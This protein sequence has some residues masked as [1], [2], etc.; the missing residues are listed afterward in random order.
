MTMTRAQLIGMTT[1][2]MDANNSA[3]WTPAVIVT[4]LGTVSAREWSGILQANPYYRF[5]QRA[6]TTDA[7]GQFLYTALNSGSADTAQN[8]SRILSITDGNNVYRQTDFMRVPVATATNQLGQQYELQWYDAGLNVQ[9][10][11]VS[12]GLS[13]IVSVNWM[14][15]RADQLSAD[16]VTVDFPDGSES[17]L[18]LEAA[19]F[20]LSKGAM[21]NNAAQTL[22]AMADQERQNMYSNISRRSA[23]PIVLGYNDSAADWASR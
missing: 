11:P 4:A 10:L 9:A 16:T 20:L 12:S 6:V 18:Y 23:R 19:A 8:W 22:R 5:A 2:M 15:P 21:E 1:E 17:V 3:R 13:L 7:N 14:P